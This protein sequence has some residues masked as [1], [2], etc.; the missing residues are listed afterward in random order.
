MDFFLVTHL[1]KPKNNIF[2][3]VCDATEAEQKRP[4]TQ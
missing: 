1:R 4:P 2:P 3:E